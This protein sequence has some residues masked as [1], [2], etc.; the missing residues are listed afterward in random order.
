M[1]RTLTGLYDSYEDAK[2]TVRELEAAGIAHEHIS[3]LANNVGERHHAPVKEGNEAGPGAGT[4][5]ALGAVVGGGAGLLAG[6][7][8]LAIPGVGPVVAAGWLIATAAGAAGGAVV[9]GAGGGL[10]GAMI[11]NGVPEE[12]AHVYAEGVRRGGTLVTVRVEDSIASTAEVILE[13]YRRVDPAVRGAAYRE[14]GWTRFDENAPAYTETELE[15][16]QRL[17]S[18]TTL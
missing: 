7:G 11:G 18:S 3:L 16:D 13:R 5:A 17:R 8:M 12:D 2:A 14:T 9:G 4:G 1:T 10:I 15:R 6:L